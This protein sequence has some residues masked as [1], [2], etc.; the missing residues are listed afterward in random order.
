MHFKS[1][2]EI[3]RSYYHIL[4][5]L[6][7]TSLK[8]WPV[9]YGSQ[10]LF[11]TKIMTCII[12]W[13]AK[14]YYVGLFIMLYYVLCSTKSCILYFINFHQFQIFQFASMCIIQC[15]HFLN[16]WCID[17]EIRKCRILLWKTERVQKCFYFI[18]DIFY[19]NFGYI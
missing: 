3:H 17:I 10:W 14:L 15:I 1:N 9:R 13:L 7:C 19:G 18:L 11:M 4:L 16:I 2:R 5:L 6:D 12:F 8:H